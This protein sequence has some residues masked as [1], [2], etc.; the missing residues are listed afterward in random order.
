MQKY[1][2]E[3]R[4]KANV[5]MIQENIDPELWKFVEKNCCI[6]SACGL[7]AAIKLTARTNLQFER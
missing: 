5:G 6:H 1:L 7:Q 2:S 4:L 3:E